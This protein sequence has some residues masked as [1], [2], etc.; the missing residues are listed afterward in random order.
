MSARNAPATPSLTKQLDEWLAASRSRRITIIPNSAVPPEAGTKGALEIRM[1]SGKRADLEYIR[2]LKN[3]PSQTSIFTVRV[4]STAGAKISSWEGTVSRPLDDVGG[5]TRVKLPFGPLTFAGEHLIHVS[6]GGRM[7]GGSPCRVRILP[8]SRSS[9]T[10]SSLHAAAADGASSSPPPPFLPPPPPPPAT[11][12]AT[13]PPPVAPPRKLVSCEPGHFTIVARDTHGN[14]RASGG[15]QLYVTV[16]RV[17][18]LKRLAR[19]RA[20]QPHSHEPQHS[21]ARHPHSHDPQHS[22]EEEEEEEEGDE[23]DGA[24]GVDETADRLA[25]LDSKDGSYRVR[26]T[27]SRSGEYQARAYLGGVALRGWLGFTIVRCLSVFACTLADASFCLHT[28]PMPPSA[29]TLDEPLSKAHSH[30]HRYHRCPARC[31]SPAAAPSVKAATKPSLATCPHS[32]CAR[33][34]GWAT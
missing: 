31:T 14:R 21:R 13:S 10:V 28:R 7:V 12:A 15:D 30:P 3:A 2:G 32:C 4:V 6:V 9:A 29:R 33:L 16:R 19:S 1:A 27:R 26:F 25:V 18:P 17:G 8:A 20:Q 11:E 5:S 34:M 22:E 23:G 24:S